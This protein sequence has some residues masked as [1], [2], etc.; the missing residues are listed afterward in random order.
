MTCRTRFQ[1]KETGRAPQPKRVPG[2]EGVS[3]FQST[4]PMLNAVE[5]NP[6]KPSS[7]APFENHDHL[8]PALDDNNVPN[9]PLQMA[10]RCQIGTSMGFVL[11][12][13]TLLSSAS[14]WGEEAKTKN[15]T[16]PPKKIEKKPRKQLDGAE[17]YAIHCNRC[18]PERYASER[19]DDQWKT[20]LLHMRTRANLPAEQAKAILRFLQE[21]SGK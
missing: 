1:A 8:D 19:T 20:I 6:M 15:S 4:K 17:L 3:W 18:H 16:Q 13:I 21:H 9:R 5:L 14:L 12:V 11:I 2:S 7:I 10:T